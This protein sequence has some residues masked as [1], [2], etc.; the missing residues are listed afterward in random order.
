MRRWLTRVLGLTRILA[1][2]TL[3]ALS[4]AAFAEPLH[5]ALYVVRDED[6]TLYLFGT[7][8]A[9][10]SGADWGGPEAHRALAEAQEV[11][12]EL[13]FSAEAD[14]RTAALVLQRGLAPPDETLSSWLTPEQRAE[15][16]AMAQSLDVPFVYLDRMRPWLAA[17]TLSM[18]PAIQAGYDPDSGADRLVVREAGNHGARLRFFETPEEQIG[19]IADMSE[20]AQRQMLL[21]ALNQADAGMEDF[22]TLDRAWE[23]GDADLLEQL[24]VE[25]LREQYPELYETVFV[26]RNAAW[27]QIL[28][29]EMRGAGVD[30]VAVGAGHLYGE[31]GLVAQMRALGYSVERVRPAE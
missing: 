21:D 4:P 2:L 20:T 24:V 30:F 14:A 13:D 29:Q 8:H 18:L 25:D 12:T 22:Q 9:R 5:P 17:I 28:E 10:P 11:W 1:A 23:S 16:E 26:R 6:S 15:I 7:I 3:C 27:M 31:H 19:F